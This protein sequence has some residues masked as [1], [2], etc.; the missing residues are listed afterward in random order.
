[1]LATGICANT[2][3]RTRSV[4]SG[5]VSGSGNNA[6]TEHLWRSISNGPLLK[7]GSFGY[8]I[9]IATNDSFFS[10]KIPLAWPNCFH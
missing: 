8:S 2:F 5:S 4:V 3:G 1:M 9:V 7:L 6:V 10:I